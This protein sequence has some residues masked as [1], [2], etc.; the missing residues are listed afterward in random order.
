MPAK[1]PEPQRQQIG[2]RVEQ[3]LITEVRVLALR[4][5]R[6]FNE[7]IEEALKDVLKKYREKGK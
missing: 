3:E 5:R 1:S 4:Q 7:L 6:R 2:A